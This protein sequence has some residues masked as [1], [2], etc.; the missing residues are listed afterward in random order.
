M[1][2]LLNNKYTEGAMD[3]MAA[4]GNG[5][6][7]I[8]TEIGKYS[9]LAGNRV[10]QLVNNIPAETANARAA[11]I[12]AM[13]KNPAVFSSGFNKE[14]NRVMDAHPNITAA[15]EVLGGAILGGGVARK[16]IRLGKD[17]LGT[18]AYKSPKVLGMG[19]KTTYY[20]PY[21]HAAAGAG[22]AAVSETIREPILDRTVGTKNF[23]SLPSQAEL[24]QVFNEDPSFV[25]T[26]LGT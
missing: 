14:R 1:T 20:T 3:R 23:P 4:V 15:G 19:G 7:N 24:L 18:Y 13:Y 12:E 26:A 22:G 17:N 2:D 10:N 16:F 25:P 6:L 5:I 21:G 9:N 11:E 8:P